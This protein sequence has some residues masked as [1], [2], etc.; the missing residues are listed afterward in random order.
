MHCRPL[1]VRELVVGFYGVACALT[2]MHSKGLVDPD[3]APENVLLS[4]NGATWV[5][6]DL[7]SAAWM[8]CNGG[9]NMVDYC[10]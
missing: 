1:T 2:H 3:L 7:G 10:M 4:P 6:A 8:E 5:K 9:P